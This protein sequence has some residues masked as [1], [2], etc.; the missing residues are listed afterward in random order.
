MKIYG[1]HF[2]DGIVKSLLTVKVAREY[3]INSADIYTLMAKFCNILAVWK[4]LSGFRSWNMR[5]DR[6]YNLRLSLKVVVNISRP[7]P[8][9][10][11]KE[12][13][14]FKQ[15]KCYNI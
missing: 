1:I 14:I 12:V 15:L 4:R 9:S 3:Y 6:S 11:E 10:N 13:Y 5:T 2:F 7:D 8:A